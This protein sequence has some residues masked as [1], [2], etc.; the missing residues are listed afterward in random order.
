MKISKS[1]LKQII[2]EELTK[3]NISEGQWAYAPDEEE[4]PEH[5]LTSLKGKEEEVENEINSILEYFQSVISAQQ[6]LYRSRGEVNFDAFRGVLR[7]LQK[8]SD[9]MY[10]QPDEDEPQ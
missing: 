5:F 7:S 4:E 9:R 3:T 2:K 10:I 1:R 6:N 8:I